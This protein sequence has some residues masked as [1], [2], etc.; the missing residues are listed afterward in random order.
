MINKGEIEP[1]NTEFYGDGTV[2][3]DN[4]HEVK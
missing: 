4:T 1:V 3:Y 2:S